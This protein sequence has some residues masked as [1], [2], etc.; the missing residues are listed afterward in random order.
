MLTIYTSYSVNCLFI[1]F[2]ANLFY[3][4]SNEEITKGKSLLYSIL[5]NLRKSV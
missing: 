2:F 4:K 1:I 3:V 5:Q